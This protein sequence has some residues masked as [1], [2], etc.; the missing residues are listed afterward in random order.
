MPFQFV[1]Q[2]GGIRPVFLVRIRRPREREIPPGG[3][4]CFLPD[5]VGRDLSHDP[6]DGIRDT[7]KGV[8]VDSGPILACR[9]PSLVQLTGQVSSTSRSTLP[10]STAYRPH[11]SDSH[12]PNLLGKWTGGS[13]RTRATLVRSPEETTQTPVCTPPGQHHV[14]DALPA[15]QAFHVAQQSTHGPRR[16][17][18]TFPPLRRNL[19]ATERPTRY[20][21]RGKLAE[22]CERFGIEYQTA[23]DAV[24]VC[25]TFERSARADL[26]TFK[27]HEAVASRPDAGELLAWAV[28]NNA[29]VQELRLKAK[30]CSRLQ[31]RLPAPVG[32]SFDFKV[33]KFSPPFVPRTHGRHNRRYPHGTA[34][35]FRPPHPWTT[36]PKKGM[37]DCHTYRRPAPVGDVLRWVGSSTWPT[38]SLICSSTTWA[39]LLFCHPAGSDLPSPGHGMDRHNSFDV[40]AFCDPRRVSF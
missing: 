3:P 29:S 21:P 40:K 7:I 8:C 1:A 33:G 2:R 11:S 24:W 5:A 20:L 32:D 10:R 17:P 27:H 28:E 19:A 30:C 4:A 38:F 18:D 13:R 23:K 35:F 34:C 31:H 37:H 16:L 22:A 12:F 6:A 26:L 15:F 9:L 39:V 36:R 25:G 14:V